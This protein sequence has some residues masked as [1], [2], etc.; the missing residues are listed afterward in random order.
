MYRRLKNILGVSLMVLA[1]VIA[2]IPMSDA[3][4]EI[5]AG[6]EAVS[7]DN[8]AYT[9]TFSM[10]G[11]TYNGT[12]NKYTFEN[13]TPVLVIDAGE[14]ISSF[15]DDKYAAYE[16]YRTEKEKWYT[17]QACLEE[18]NQA[19]RISDN[20][21]LYK[22]W[23][24]ITSDGSTLA[25]KGFYINPD[26]TVLYK[27]DGDEILVTI[28]ASVTTIA[29]GAF[30]NLENVKGIILPK[31]IN[32][33]ESNAFSGLKDGSI[34]YI[35]DSET[36]ESIA[37]G[38]TLA[39][40][41]P[42]L[43]YSKYLSAEDVQKIVGIDY[44]YEIAETEEVQLAAENNAD[45][46][47]QNKVDKVLENGST[48][49]SGNTI[50]EGGSSSENGNTASGNSST[51]ESSNTTS[52]SNSKQESANGVTES[53]T[54]PESGNTASE[55]SSTPESS[56]ATSESDSKQE[57]ANGVTESNA[58]PESGNATA[59]SSSTPE[60]STTTPESSTT[61]E[62]GSATAES[63]STP[64]SSTTSENNGGSE[65]E[66]SSSVIVVEPDQKYT[67]TFQTGIDGV[68]GEKREVL[69]GRTV[70]E[71]VSIR[72]EQ[73]QI[74]KK[75]TYQIE[76][77]DGKQELTYTFQGWYKD[78]A[79]T[80]EWNFAN[81]IIEADTT[82][83]AKW[84]LATRKYFYV[85]FSAEGASN[86]PDE[87]KLY[88]DEEL[89]KPSK[90]PSLNKQNF[91]GWYTSDTDEKSKFTAWNKPVTEDMTLYARFEEKG[92]TVVFHM[93]GGG[94]TGNYAN[95]SYTDAASLKKKIAVGK[96][97]SASDYPENG[98]SASFKYSSY[99]T[100]SNWYTD[101]ECLNV[102]AKKNSSGNDTV[103]NGD[104]TLYKR[105]Y[106][107]SSGFTMNPAGNILYKY[108]GNVADV[109]IPASVTTIAA[110][111][112]ASVGSIS[113]ITLPDN[114]ADVKPNAFSGVNNITKDIT[115]TGASENANNVAKGL[116]NQY[117]HLVYKEG[118]KSN[119][120]S[121]VS[122]AESGTIKLGAALSGAAGTK[123]AAAI[124]NTVKA[125]TNAGSIKLGAET[126]E[127]TSNKSSAA[128]PVTATQPAATQPA[129]AIQ[130]ITVTQSAPATQPAT[131]KQST[132]GKQPA[133]ANQ[134]SQRASSVA[135][136]SPKNASSSSTAV[137]AGAKTTTKKNP[138]SAS[139][140][141]ST[142]HVKDSTPKTGDPIQYR[143]LIVYVMFSIG[144]LLLL[145]GNGKKRKASAS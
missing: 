88:E 15:P 52:E 58:T 70:S 116:A 27:Y 56:N 138:T 113:S 139:A 1:I 50:S 43:V 104:L 127:G 49:E 12:Y 110:N 47:I 19:S 98:K 131:D 81:D 67:V 21:T 33:I 143:M 38:K 95:T 107:T 45:S 80:T 3:N 108:N 57:S 82:I 136:A 124:A 84:D 6:Q 79:C 99:S 135:A 23:F 115:I 63:S 7:K 9:V 76:K 90:N 117:K 29:K 77:D 37:Y 91:T 53:S 35:F 120:G 125:A 103:L 4:A 51:P 89:K 71:M 34:V 75:N 87:Q 44:G 118:K 128:Q 121:V 26:G 41:Y 145:T 114:I 25:Q 111:A 14:T 132:T 2:Q 92:Y 22:R 140:P 69:S 46:D 102:Y 68:T 94:F 30:D 66:S 93:N 126:K 123:T 97:I 39:Q 17:D 5:P 61:P 112:F 74:L 101:K 78:K 137:T 105:W 106:Y 62:S 31:N 144:V 119:D 96:G 54:T 48:P 122:I 40:E 18:F 129:A 60:S 28:P 134:P 73:P 141:R 133:A 109:V 100:D 8:A 55:S 16:G 65:T 42:Q 59:E 20:T 130:P 36:S 86:V 32:Q 64:E 11:G 72:D 85:K 142:E 83:Y 24:N 10:N 13:K